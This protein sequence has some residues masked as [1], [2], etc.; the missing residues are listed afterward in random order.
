MQQK[1]YKYI[2]I[3]VQE[4]VNKATPKKKKSNKVK[5]LPEKAL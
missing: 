5:W 1:I 4:V 2:Y 3:C